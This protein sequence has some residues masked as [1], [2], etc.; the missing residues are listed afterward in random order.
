MTLYRLS[1]R[2]ELRGHVEVEADSAWDAE[3]TA[4]MHVPTIDQSFET[5]DWTI[6][7]A[8]PHPNQGEENDHG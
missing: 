5:T 7:K 1:A 2:V 3:V 6:G 4:G 8:I